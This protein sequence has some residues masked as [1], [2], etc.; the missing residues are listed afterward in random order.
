MRPI[1]TYF[2]LVVDAYIEIFGLL[3]SL[4]STPWIIGVHVKLSYKSQDPCNRRH[5]F[6]TQ[7]I[8][9][10]EELVNLDL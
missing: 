4:H 7:A 8:P 10:L 9:L 6:D 1:F 2:P 3:D 5:Y